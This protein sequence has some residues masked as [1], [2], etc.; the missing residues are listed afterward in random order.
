MLCPLS[1]LASF[2][3]IS[4][5]GSNTPVQNF[6]CPQYFRRRVHVPK[7]GKKLHIHCVYQAPHFSKFG[8]PISGQGAVICMLSPPSDRGRHMLK[9]RSDGKFLYGHSKTDNGNADVFATFSQKRRSYLGGHCPGP[10]AHSVQRGCALH[11]DVISLH[12][13]V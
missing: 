2:F 8:A 7:N 3:P 1:V 4:R 13:S 12:S 9:I 10:P 11:S 5:A 6:A